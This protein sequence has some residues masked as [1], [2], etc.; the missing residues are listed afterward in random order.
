MAALKKI[1]NMVEKAIKKI[2]KALNDLKKEVPRMRKHLNK[3]TTK[4]VK[5][6]Q[7]IQESLSEDLEL[8]LKDLGLNSFFKK[9]LAEAV[10]VLMVIA[11]NVTES[12]RPVVNKAIQLIKDFKLR[13]KTV[14]ELTILAK[15]FA[16]TLS[17]IYTET[18]KEQFEILQKQGTVLYAKAMKEI[19][20]YL[21]RAEKIAMEYKQ[22]AM[23]MTE[24]Y[25]QV[26]M[27]MSEDYSKLAVEMAAEY[28]E[29]ATVYLNEQH[30]EL[31]KMKVP[32]MKETV[33]EVIEIIKAKIEELK[34]K[35]E[36]MKVKMD[37][38]KIKVEEIRTKI[39]NME[40]EKMM[41]E[42][43]DMILS[44]KINAQTVEVH[45]KTM[46]NTLNK[47][48]VQAKKLLK[49]LK[50]LIKQYKK[51]IKMVY[52]EIIQFA[53][54]MTNHIKFV[55]KSAV[56]R[57]SP[58]IKKGLKN[59]D[60]EMP[61]M[62][63][64]PEL[65]KPFLRYVEK[66]QRAVRLFLDPLVIPLS[67]MYKKIMKQV[68]MINIMSVRVG[69]LMDLNMAILSNNIEV[70]V[71]KAQQ[72]L[73]L[74]M[75][76]MTK[77]VEE[78]SK[79]SPEQIVDMAVE[80]SNKMSDHAV[81]MSKQAMEYAKKMVAERQQ[82]MKMTEEQLKKI[83]SHL[84][85]IYNDIVIQYNALKKQDA[86]AVMKGH[87]KNI[88]NNVLAIVD[89]IQS[90]MKQIS[91][92]DI[93]GPAKQAWK[94][95]DVVKHLEKYGIDQQ[96]AK[97][98]VKKLKNI[99]I[100][101]TVEEVIER[102]KEFYNMVLAESLVQA[103]QVYTKI[104]SAAKYVRSIPK[105]EYEQWYQELRSF[106]LENKNSFVK[107]ATKT[108]KIS[109]KTAV[110]LYTAL[111]SA[112]QKN[113]KELA[114]FYNTRAL[115]V[116]NDVAGQVSLFYADV[117]Q[118]TIDVVAYYQG[119]A[120][121]AYTKYNAMYTP[122]VRKFYKDMEMQADIKVEELKIKAEEMYVKAEELKALALI[123]IEELKVKVEEYRVIAVAK[124]EEIVLQ[125]EQ[126]YQIFLEK[127]GDMT[128]EEVAEQAI[129]FGEA[130]FAM[131]QAEYTKNM[132]LSQEL[133]VKYKAIAE[134]MVEKYR[135]VVEKMVAEY[136]S[137][138][139]KMVIVYKDQAQK[140][141]DETYAKV[142]SKYEKY[143][144][145]FESEIKP[146]IMAEYK[147]LVAMYEQGMIKYQELKKQVETL[148][149]KY[150][151][152]VLEIRS[153]VEAKMVEMRGIADA[154][155]EEIQG[156]VMAVYNANK[157]KSLK[158]IYR[159]IKAIILDEFNKQKTILISEF[160]K[161][162][163][164]AIAQYNTQKDFIIT[165]YKKQ[166]EIAIIEFNKQVKL[167]A[168]IYN[169]KVEDV[170]KMVELM[171]FVARKYTEEMKVSAGKYAET[172]RVFVKDSEKFARDVVMPELT[173]E[174]Q[175]IVKQTLKNVEIMREVIIEA[176][177]PHYTIIIREAK[178]ALEEFNKFSKMAVKE[179][180]KNYKIAVNKMTKAIEQSQIEL[181]KQMEELKKMINEL[182]KQA[183]EHEYTKTAVQY[184][185]KASK[186]AMKFYKQTS[187]EIMVYYQK[188]SAKAMIY[189]KKAMAQYKKA[190]NSKFVTKTMKRLR[191]L[192]KLIKQ[193]I[194]QLKAHPVTPKYT[195]LARKQYIAV[196]EEANRVQRKLKKMLK[197]PRYTKMHKQMKKTMHK[198][199]KSAEFTYNKLVNKM[200]P[201]LKRARRSVENKMSEAPKHAQKAVDYFMEQPKEAF[202]TLV[203][204][205]NAFFKETY[206]TIQEIDF[207]E[208]S[209]N[210]EQYIN[211][212]RNLLVDTLEEI[213]D[214][215]TKTSVKS[216]YKKTIAMSEE[217]YADA[218]V[219][220]KD[221]TKMMK[222]MK[223]EVIQMYNK[224][225][226]EAIQ[227]RMEAEK[228]LKR[229][230]E[231]VKQMAAQ[232]Y[233]ENLNELRQWYKKSTNTIKQQYKNSKLRKMVENQIW[234]EI[235][236]EIKRHELSEVAYDAAVFTGERA[237]E[238]KSVAVKELTK[239][240]KV[241]EKK[242]VEL[243]AMAMDKYA[244]LKAVSM[245]K[246]A[247][248][249][250]MS[251]Q[252]YAEIKSLGLQK[253][254]KMTSKVEE[255][256]QQMTVF[257]KD[258]IVTA[259]KM[260]QNLDNFLETTTL[261]E[262]VELVQTNF[263]KTKTQVEKIVR[264]NFKLA[265]QLTKEYEVIAK[266][267][268]KDT[269]VKIQ[270]IYKEEVEP[271][272]EE[273]RT[274]TMEQFNMIKSQ[275][276]QQYTKYIE[277]VLEQYN[278]YRE[279]AIGQFNI[280]REQA[281]GQYD[282]YYPQAEAKYNEA[283][284]QYM[285]L[286]EQAMNKYQIYSTLAKKMFNTYKVKAI[287][288]YGEIL[289][290]VI[291]SSIRNQLMSLKKMTIKETIQS[292][293]TIPT[294]VKFSLVMA[295]NK[296]REY[297]F[298]L[299]EY[300]V[301]LK[302]YERM[303]KKMFGDYSV[304]A[305]DE[306]S[307][308]YNEMQTK[309]NDMY[310][311]ILKEYKTRSIQLVNI[312]EPYTTPMVEAYKWVENEV[313]ETARFVYRYHRVEE[314]ALAFAQF[315]IEEYERL[316]PIVQARVEEI[317]ELMMKEYRNKMVEANKMIAQYKQLTVEYQQMAKDFYM[318]NQAQKLAFD[319]VAN[320]GDMT[321][322]GIH[323]GMK[324]VDSIDFDNLKINMPEF[325]VYEKKILAY[326]TE[327]NKYISIEDGRISIN[328]PHD[329]IKTKITKIISQLDKKAQRTVRIA[330]E[331]TKKML[332]AIT[333]ELEK[334]QARAEVLRRQITRSI[335]ENTVEVRKDLQKSMS[336]NNR[337]AKRVYSN[338]KLWAQKTF[339][340]T[341]IK[342]IK[343]QVESYM[344]KTQRISMKYYNQ[345]IRVSQ[346]MYL[347]SSAIFMDIYQAG[348]YKMHKRAYFHANRV[349]T[350]VRKQSNKMMKQYKPVV[351][352]YSKMV[353]VEL[354]QMKKNV[355]PYYRS[356][357]KIYT[358]IRMGVSIQKALNLREF[359]FVSREYQR[360]AIKT[361]SKT[362]SMFCK[363]D[364]KLC[365]YMNEASRVH[366]QLFN[367][368]SARV[369]D[370]AITNKAR[371]DR[372]LRLMSRY[373]NRPMFGEHNVAA[374]MFDHYVMTFDKSYFQMGEQS[375]DCS[376]L[377]AHDF[378]ENQF[379]VKKVRNISFFSK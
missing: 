150:K 114:K 361:L 168:E 282:I 96:K 82:Y 253:Y 45:M 4:V 21:A 113:Y 280:Y 285:E 112:S 260:V 203:D 80:S 306:Y 241:M 339:R 360:R 349:Y 310:A 243:K 296:I 329:E 370:F 224:M 106:A 118:P 11:N 88:E 33:A 334:V 89:E 373:T 24:E 98:I 143:V 65:K 376:Y 301:M 194:A 51:Q 305:F 369:A 35:V 69:P 170:D 293:K 211:D 97:L 257:Y 107:F 192:I 146:K 13:G 256:Y 62:P 190:L 100:T 239:Q 60:F 351:M 39:V 186:Q 7:Q 240:Q 6:Y 167:I 321:L 290:R 44:Y 116:Y 270:K 295:Q 268:Y 183:Q 83:Y 300:Q 135:G 341:S 366:K 30:K 169:V 27:K 38:I 379:T 323:S 173:Q 133:I 115:P 111:V 3:M 271:K 214:E 318:N 104:Q 73:D 350:N 8:T 262:L 156:K 277:Q 14:E 191:Q 59:V 110:E 274:K 53:E 266:D 2:I 165:E 259:N 91:K 187:E 344:K 267:M 181:K 228:T 1:N 63:E 77:L 210:R 226:S 87:Y 328:F 205:I 365:K 85:T 213:T 357:K 18:A 217:M 46:K 79:M 41:A 345:M 95:A 374:I 129:K 196:N 179:F 158:K 101:K 287:E 188:A 231:Q 57:F 264:E 279:Q 61:E 22:L 75:K 235:I 252:K 289:T 265:Q 250:S 84:K 308:K 166:K 29:K 303:V 317:Q 58:L 36:E 371:F 354:A 294:Q 64:M 238:F 31:L 162:K 359:V 227:M 102:V 81:V 247:E 19:T 244:E 378:A 206:Q 320:A 76:R 68:R 174:M 346:K 42:A 177:T 54:P 163:S 377:L 155:F 245:E 137:K 333:K 5:Y 356:A 338:G 367:K 15:E 251:I 208:I 233:K 263:K 20:K 335:M 284:A 254:A 127:Y 368:Y 32:Y 108:Y 171:K 221:A 70:Y 234:N 258:A 309:S 273:Y 93:S 347:Q 145:R 25:K 67:P 136:R 312:V 159:E 342:N 340:K 219:M 90:V 297:Q 292:L 326:F 198:M 236:D 28:T 9:D 204:A 348:I 119:V 124:V 272:I 178:I 199:Q 123:R 375:K 225:Y 255:T 161:Q 128:W 331:E 153:I 40:P 313:K 138:A 232:Q 189:Y 322:R 16:V 316:A 302:E 72:M 364:P 78:Y 201:S 157:D 237:D 315:S 131:I 372:A 197:D 358:N 52:R 74:E 242:F 278:I 105:K 220:I 337:I 149:V 99:Q 288:M 164:F 26:A 291:E 215:W 120:T 212:A 17:K 352:K 92:L 117:K 121:T 184:Y 66:I 218:V 325:A 147:K 324:F 222:E 230:P 122:V 261:G 216:M 246:Y 202:W 307:K 327:I 175:S 148:I 50:K 34:V 56:K 172:A 275:V 200:T 132:K 207:N 182:V 209:K 276:L 195:K 185:N 283:Y 193:K 134:Q 229:L 160:E 139:E 126:Q 48:P 94:D 223:K 140:M 151:G 176:Y 152:Q 336:I 314:R 142:A 332:K 343:S 154:K 249:E 37:E 180:N 298:M 141:Y 103:N 86:E 362:K 269:L 12:S 10:R 281:I 355:L 248:I 71:K 330:K 49:E 47:L 55:T 125:M 299:K 363:R 130:K 23:K 43:K 311:N 109:S 144:A 319:A 286:K 304:R 353:R